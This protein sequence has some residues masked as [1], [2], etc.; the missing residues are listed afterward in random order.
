MARVLNFTKY[1][2]GLANPIIIALLEVFSVSEE[3]PYPN[4]KPQSLLG[5]LR[6]KAASKS[7]VCLQAE[8]VKRYTWTSSKDTFPAEWA[9]S[10]LIVFS[11]HFWC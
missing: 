6:R 2:L 3:L 10:L 8:T 11:L 1:E 9:P 7:R 4:T 5:F